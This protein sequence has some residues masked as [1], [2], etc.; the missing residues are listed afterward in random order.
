MLISSMDPL[1]PSLSALKVTAN[2]I[3]RAA[4]TTFSKLDFVEKMLEILD[5]AVNNLNNFIGR[6]YQAF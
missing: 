5:E 4:I 2:K 3:L 6:N 1:N